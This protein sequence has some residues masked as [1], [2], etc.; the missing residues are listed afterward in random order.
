[1]RW[2]APVA[3]HELPTLFAKCPRALNR[4]FAE[5]EHFTFTNGRGFS[6]DAAKS[7]FFGR[8]DFYNDHLEGAAKILSLGKRQPFVV[9]LLVF[10][11]QFFQTDVGLRKGGDVKWFQPSLAG[12]VS[13]GTALR[14]FF[15]DPIEKGAANCFGCLA[16]QQHDAFSHWVRVFVAIDVVHKNL[17]RKSAFLLI[18]PHQAARSEKQKR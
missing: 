3:P 6:S 18:I 2:F 17:C 14:L 1:M 12:N 9:D 7:E 8:H 11:L 15:L 5:S 10:T 16:R 4:L 13:L